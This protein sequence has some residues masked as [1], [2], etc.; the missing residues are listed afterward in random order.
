[1]LTIYYTPITV[2]E[3]TPMALIEQ[4]LVENYEHTPTLERDILY[5]YV[6]HIY[7]RVLLLLN[8]SRNKLI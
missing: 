6:T 3:Y 8:Q 5:S 7:Y 1:M 4:P 2:V